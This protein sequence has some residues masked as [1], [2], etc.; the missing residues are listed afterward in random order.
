[1][2]SAEREAIAKRALAASTADQTEV[3]VSVSDS[4]LT[5]FTRGISNQN[6]AATDRSIS[7]RAIVGG[8][9]GVASTNETSDAAVDAVTARAIALAA[10]A[11]A[12]P[13]QPALPSGGA[14]PTP[15]GAYV[16]TTAHADP[17]ARAHIADAIV[18]QAEIAG[19]WGAGYVATSSSGITIANSAGA[20][21]SFD[22]TD[23][24]ANV[25]VIADDSSG[26]AEHYATDIERIDGHEIG[27]RAV[28]KTRDGANPR[29]VEPGPWTVI[30]EPPAI[31]ELLTYLLSHFSAQSY[32]E[33]SSFFSGRLGERFFADGVTIRDDYAHPLAPGMPFDYEA[34][35]KTRPTLVERGAVREIVTDSYYAH[36]LGRPNTGHALPAPNAWGPQALNVVVDP[37][38]TSAD[39]LISQTERGL[40]IS[41]FWYIRT[42]DQKRA[43]VTGMTRDGTFLIDHGR[44]AGGVRNLRFNQSIV[45]AL[46]HAV[47]AN[48][49]HRTGGYGYSLV[50][51]TV[52]I[53]GFR[54]TSTTE[55]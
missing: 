53:E 55:F 38:S 3:I 4:A 23:A 37:G 31:G 54:F 44:I 32:D 28:T 17:F 35:P 47:F 13:Q 8:R 39:E 42:V 18:S 16:E 9:T 19:F 24:Q 48:D 43:I 51:P 6:V 2:T 10:F 14:T 20:L 26:F 29:S 34:Q 46:A 1:M 52:K 40:L 27:R 30:L 22:G 11:P 45:D 21:A 36:K 25:K 15:P 12:D 7:V 5:R 49:A 33:G 41:R 50:V